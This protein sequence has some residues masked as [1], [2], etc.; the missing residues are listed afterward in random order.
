M[1]YAQILNGIV[2]N[3]IV[4]TDT[5]LVSVF[6]EGFDYFIQIGNLTPQPGI[7][8]SYNGTNFTPASIM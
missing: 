6:S 2:V 4:L 1:I 8:W 5:N 7:G 3:T